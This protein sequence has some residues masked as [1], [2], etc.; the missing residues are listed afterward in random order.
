MTRPLLLIEWVDSYGCSARWESLEDVAD[1]ELNTC[2]SVGW[3]V[4][5][6]SSVLVLVPHIAT[7]TD[8]TDEQGCGDM[9][10]PQQ[11]VV[12]RTEISSF[13]WDVL[14]PSSSDRV[15]E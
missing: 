14:S 1:P 5:E 12:K 10:I 3:L 13:S 2:R 7:E 8:R 4:K 6:N 11:C 9:T 15:L